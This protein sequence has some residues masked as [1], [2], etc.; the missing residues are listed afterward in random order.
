M[1]IR[2]DIDRDADDW[3]EE[4]LAVMEQVKMFRDRMLSMSLS[5]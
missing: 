2:V 5:A 4:S 1:Q 3:L